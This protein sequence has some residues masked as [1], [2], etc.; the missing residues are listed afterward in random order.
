LEK[1]PKRTA[2]LEK[3]L[4]QVIKG[5][6]KLKDYDLIDVKNENGKIINQ[7]LRKK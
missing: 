7:F 6:D 2:I 5:R 4:E 3:R 1:S